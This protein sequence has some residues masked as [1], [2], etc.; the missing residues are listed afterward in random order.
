MHLLSEFVQNELAEDQML[1]VLRQ[2]L[3]ILLTIL[4]NP[5]IH[6]HLTRARAISVFRQC[7]TALNMVRKEY[8]DAV[9]EALTTV[10]PEWIQAFQVLLAQDPLA[11]VANASDWDPLAIRIQIFKT[12]DII[13]TNFS[14][15]IRPFVEQLLKLT[16][17]NLTTLMP[18]FRSYYLT[19]SGNPPP[20]QNADD[21]DMTVSLQHLAC[22][23]LDFICEAARKQKSVI[24]VGENVGDIINLALYWAQMTTED[25]GPIVL[26]YR[27]K[28]KP[29]DRKKLGRTM[30]TLSFAMKRP[31]WK[32][33]LPE[34]VRSISSPYVYITRLLILKLNP[35]TVAGS[36]W[37]G[38][39]PSSRAALDCDLATGRSAC[40]GESES[41]T[42]LVETSRSVPC[43]NRLRCRDRCGRRRKGCQAAGSYRRRTALGQDSP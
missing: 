19:G 33:I 34:S 11:D 36:C 22:P 23:A 17:Q 40:R 24:W 18:V 12:L 4:G 9:K 27:S 41:P 16:A 38:Q 2:L 43:R 3:P 42:R 14:A 5:T 6:S 37:L 32:H 15:A 31:T 39:P 30:P 7:V 28:L 21:P 29:S 10:L 13:Q 1:P 20:P 26:L 8:P 25:V 35:Y